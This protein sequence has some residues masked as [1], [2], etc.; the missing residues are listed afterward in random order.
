M[1]FNPNIKSHLSNFDGLTQKSGTSGTHNLDAFNQ[2]AAANSV[3]VLSETPTSVAG[4]TTVRY[5]I[6]AYDRA[7]NVVGYKNQVFPK[8]VYDPKVFTDHK[9]RCQTTF[10]EVVGISLQGTLA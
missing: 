3:K 1:S 2:V 4:V 8:T 6:P 9:I 7:G 10:S 5:Q